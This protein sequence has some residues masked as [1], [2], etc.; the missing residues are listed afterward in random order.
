[1]LTHQLKIIALSLLIIAL[2]CL[3]AFYLFAS[4]ASSAIKFINHKH[5]VATIYPEKVSSPEKLQRGLMFRHYLPEDQ[6]MLFIFPE[7]KELNFWMENTYIPLD[8]IFLNANKEIV[9]IHKNVQPCKTV[10]CPTY[11]SLK[12][13]QYAIEVNA[14]FVDK[15]QIDKQTIV[16]F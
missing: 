16:Q 8:I 15:Y 14:G 12:P 7:E 11:A 10:K 4:K 13:A 1:M 9:R 5:E 2:V 6:G 3:G